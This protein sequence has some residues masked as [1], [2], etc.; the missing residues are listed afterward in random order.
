MLRTVG[1]VG[2]RRGASEQPPGAGTPGVMRGE[3]P[4]PPHCQGALGVSAKDWAPGQQVSRRTLGH[5]SVRQRTS[6][7]AAWARTPGEGVKRG[8]AGEPLKWGAPLGPEGRSG[9]V[10]Q[11]PGQRAPTGVPAAVGAAGKLP[12]GTPGQPALEGAAGQPAQGTLG[13]VWGRRLGQLVG[14]GL[15]TGHRTAGNVPEGSPGMLSERAPRVPPSQ[16]TPGQPAWQRTPRPSVEP[17]TS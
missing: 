8:A 3:V 10:R 5:P 13:T 7:D 17:W 14:Q 12:L 16:R 1:P 15:S 9:T 2:G 4:W 6:R 11:S